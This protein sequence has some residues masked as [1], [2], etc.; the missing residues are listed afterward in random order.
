MLSS[1]SGSPYSNTCAECTVNRG[2]PRNSAPCPV[3]VTSS[4]RAQQATTVALIGTSSAGRGAGQ[5]QWRHD[6]TAP[7]RPSPSRG[8]GKGRSAR[9][10]GAPAAGRPVPDDVDPLPALRAHV[11]AHLHETPRLVP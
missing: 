4:V 8:R 6:L 3:R 5:A 11:P 9:D 7:D 2:L 1:P 10:L